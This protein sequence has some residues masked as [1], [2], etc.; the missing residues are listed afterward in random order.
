MEC[1]H[2]KKRMPTA[3]VSHLSIFLL[4]F[5]VLFCFLNSTRCPIVYEI[6]CLYAGHLLLAIASQP[7]SKGHNQYSVSPQTL[8]PMWWRMFNT[9]P[10]NI[11]IYKRTYMRIYG[12]RQ[13]PQIIECKVEERRYTN[14]QWIKL[15]GLKYVK[16]INNFT[17]AHGWHKM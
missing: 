14:E 8:L 12:G 13:R 11:Q 5:F 1:F 2:R 10:I 16:P 3:F 6:N 9:L 15:F 7:Y 4:D 17:K